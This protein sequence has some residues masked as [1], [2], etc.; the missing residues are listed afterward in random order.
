MDEI[1]QGSKSTAKNSSAAD[2]SDSDEMDMDVDTLA[3]KPSRGISADLC[4][5]FV[6]CWHAPSV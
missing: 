1:L 3:P 5:N 2:D 4:T 6:V